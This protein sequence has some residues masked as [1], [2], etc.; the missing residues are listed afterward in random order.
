VLSSQLR[1]GVGP[2]CAAAA[3]ERRCE[4]SRVLTCP[5]LLPYGVPFARHLQY[6]RLL[7]F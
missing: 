6:M 3:G 7:P 5:R 1:S 4:A 2:T